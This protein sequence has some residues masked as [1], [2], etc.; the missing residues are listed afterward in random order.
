MATYQKLGTIN[1]PPFS[2]DPK[3]MIEDVNK[4]FY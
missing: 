1:L 2:A 4:I 3:V